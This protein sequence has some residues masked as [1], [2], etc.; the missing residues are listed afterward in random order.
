MPEQSQALR[1]IAHRTHPLKRKSSNESM[2]KNKRWERAHTWL[3]RRR[4][5]QEF[6][7]YNEPPMDTTSGLERVSSFTDFVYSEI[8]VFQSTGRDHGQ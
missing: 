7:S 6:V 8:H 5:G 4:V 2:W 3:K 1:T